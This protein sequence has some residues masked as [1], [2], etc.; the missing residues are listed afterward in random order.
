MLEGAAALGPNRRREITT[1]LV[2]VICRRKMPLHI[3]NLWNALYFGY[4]LSSRSYEFVNIDR[5]PERQMHERAAYIPV[6]GFVR[7]H[8]ATKCREIWGEVIYKEGRH[9]DLESGWVSA[10]LSGAPA[11]RDEGDAHADLSE[12]LVLDYEAFG[13]DWNECKPEQFTRILRKQQWLD[14]FGHLVM[15]AVYSAEFANL[16][17]LTIFA[18]YMMTEHRDGLL[19]PQLEEAATDD[20]VYGA[21]LS[22]LQTIVDLCRD[23]QELRTWGNYVLDRDSYERQIRNEGC[24]G[25][26][27]LGH[28][29]RG[30]LQRPGDARVG[31][32]AI[33]P[34]IVDCLEEG[35]LD[36][37]ERALLTGTE[38]A[39]TIVTANLYVVDRLHRDAQDGA[40]D[41]HHLRL[42]DPWQGGGIWRVEKLNGRRSAYQ[43]LPPEIPLHICSHTAAGELPAE[44]S[45]PEPLET[46]QRGWRMVITSRDLDLLQ[47]RLTP[48]VADTLGD[49]RQVTVR[50]HIPPDAPLSSEASFL[51][52]ARRVEGV[53]YPLAAF[54]GMVLTGNVERGGAV[55]KLRAT[56]LQQPVTIGGHQVRYEI[57]RA[58]YEKF[59]E[60]TT[61]TPTSALSLA[62]LV[63]N[64]IRRHGHQDG[65]GNRRL[66]VAEIVTSILGP[67]PNEEAARAILAGLDDLGLTQD[68][69]E[70]VLPAKV[71][72]Q[73][74]AGARLALEDSQQEQRRRS[75]VRRWFTPMHVRRLTKTR[76]S[77]TK[78]DGYAAALHEVRMQHIL[79]TTLPENAT[80]V[81]GHYKGTADDS[82]ETDSTK[83]EAVTSDEV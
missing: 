80:W 54:P 77:Q 3:A 79:P 76:P 51:P 69:S 48:S 11:R 10:A 68:G 73:T 8:T 33:A 59:L 36:E 4:R 82:E 62:D 70:Y 65:E 56:P 72:R 14:E 74:R 17:D 67:A 42:D 18:R 25:G 28:I 44:L 43:L 58:A 35:G 9:P 63:E 57:D 38:Y 29:F 12:L 37:Q 78:I 52:G 2:D 24:L 39:R 47:V 19:G 23:C 53:A 83:L 22:S 15:E 71:G 31:Y 41:D 1:F 64:V 81:K 60:A 5:V 26:G 7:V 27:D 45:P 46:S 49:A 13:K 75:L 40:I 55:L 6:G 50:I 16:D 34:R 20:E 32:A 21:L 61:T 66:P 30:L